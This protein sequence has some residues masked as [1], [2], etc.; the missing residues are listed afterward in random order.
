MEVRLEEEVGGLQKATF[1]C[2]GCFVQHQKS[3]ITHVNIVHASLPPFKQSLWK[4]RNKH[5]SIKYIPSRNLKN[6]KSFEIEDMKYSRL[7][8][9][10]DD[11]REFVSMCAN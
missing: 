9:D 6:E 1:L 11:E 4:G 7:V 3:K 8:K 2:I 5:T 10:E